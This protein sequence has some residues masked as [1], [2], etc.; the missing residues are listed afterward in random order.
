[1]LQDAT[2]PFFLS[3]HQDSKS[4]LDKPDCII[5]GEARITHGPGAGEQEFEGGEAEEGGV[6]KQEGGAG[7]QEFEGG[8]EKQEGGVGEQEWEGGLTYILEMIDS[9]QV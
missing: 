7:E 4:S 3:V 5:P 9:F 6:G 1:M 2:N 8:V